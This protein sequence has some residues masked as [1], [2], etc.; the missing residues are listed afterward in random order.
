L[1]ETLRALASDPARLV[2]M[3]D[4][5]RRL[6]RPDA[7]RVIAEDFLALAGLDAG[8]APASPDPLSRPRATEESVLKLTEVA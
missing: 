2:A 3:A 8:A 1:A 6:G 4:S 7:A 5:A